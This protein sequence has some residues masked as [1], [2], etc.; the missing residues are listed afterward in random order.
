MPH[1]NPP[2]EPE[3]VHTHCAGCGV[4]L[5]I[6]AWLAKWK[7]L[8]DPCALKR[9]VADQEQIRQRALACATPKGE[10]AYAL[11]RKKGKDA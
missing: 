1:M 8:C 4:E 7:T 6:R 5:Q 11:A 3:L 9:A 10:D 2:A